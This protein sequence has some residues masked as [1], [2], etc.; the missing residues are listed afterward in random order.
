MQ[1][2]DLCGKWSVREAGTDRAIKASVPGC[3]HT[4]LL[5]AK[6]IPDPFY[7][8]NEKELLWIGERD[9]IYSREFTVPKNILDHDAAILLCDGL[10]SLAQIRLNGTTLGQTNNM[11]RRWE[12]NVKG[13]LRSGSGEKP[14]NQLEI[15]FFS[16]FPYIRSQQRKRYLHHTGVGHHR[17]E[18]ANRVRKAQCNYGWDWGP[19]C[20]TC[21]IWRP[22]RLIAFN[23]ARIR[24]VSI[25][26]NHSR[27]RGVR[28]KVRVE[29][30]RRDRTALSSSISVTLK[31]KRIAEGGMRFSGSSGAA[32]VVVSDPQL[33]WPN[34]MGNQPLY[35][36]EVT[37]YD[38]RGARLDTAAR[39][40]GLRT[41]RLVRE[42]DRWGESFY[43]E[44]NGKAFFS[45]GANWIPADVFVTRTDAS[46]YE[47][48]IRSAAEAH[49]NMLRVWGGGIYEEDLF[50]DLCDRYGLCVWQDFMFACGAYPAYDEDFMEN[51]RLEAEDNVR[52]LRHHP[53]LAL[54]CGNNEIEMIPGFVGDD[55]E[56]GQMSWN[57]YKS[58]FD[59]LLPKV[60]RQLDPQR[61]Y[62]P[63][64]SHSPRG[65]RK[66][67]NNPRW[68]DAHLWKVWHGREPFEWYR[69]CEH[70]FN[71][72]F[73]FQSFPEPKMVRTYT[74]S[75]DR[76]VTSYIMEQHQRSQI[77]N[78]AIITYMLDWF[79][80][81]SSFDMT[82]WL[83]QILQGLA[84]KYAVENWRRKKPQGMG[85]L[86]W[87]LNDC[88]PVASW[89][90]ID[91]SGRWKALHFMAKRFFAPLLVSA[92]ENGEEGTVEVHA[93]SDLMEKTEGELEWSVTD[94]SG[95]PLDRGKREVTL[96][97]QKSLK[98]CTLRLKDHLSAHGDRRVLVW[99]S[100]KSKN[101]FHSTN[102]ASFARP[103]HLEL[104]VPQ[105]KYRAREL[106]G[107]G[108]RLV[109]SSRTPALWVWIELESTE[110]AYSDNFFHLAPGRSVTVDV[111]PN[112]KLS[113]T[114]FEKKLRI[115]SLVDTYTQ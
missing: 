6:A 96:A 32:D 43:F 64:S 18:G 100:L 78:E 87:Q 31:G 48:L 59:R 13:L 60:V 62:W 92:I 16:T 63:S 54:W 81:P 102:L 7:R 14:K 106:A 5:A 57:E 25:E 94:A 90:S 24:D 40:I 105:I 58:L 20:V 89:S 35:E 71:S 3:V 69:G 107:R 111:Y 33:W 80:L 46:L 39:S 110:A 65:D 26:Q 30:D 34:G 38:A 74:E 84:I 113:L 79:R 22:I 29:V 4:D 108:F 88:W 44:V 109:L 28:L 98:A 47:H 68:G 2:I 10:D 53:S 66:D 114:Q 9:W 112:R 70:R 42:S 86:Y 85:T 93:C 61:A 27:G 49:M 77:G 15:R 41:L 8:D 83:S 115:R 99:L 67:A 103:K 104:E 37:L 17:L 45:K 19:M 55:A 1:S 52:R 36:V 73:G 76:N 11:F 23:V 21:G 97:A 82:L 101:G 12:Y 50:Y 56:A 72:E 51:V 95:K 91:Y 75:G